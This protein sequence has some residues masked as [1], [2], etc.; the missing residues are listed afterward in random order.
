MDDYRA[1]GAPEWG[2]EIGRIPGP[3]RCW[4]GE[5]DAAVPVAVGRRVADAIPGAALELVP[6][7]GHFL[8]ADHGTEVFTGLLAD[9]G[10]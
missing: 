9:G 3:V 6:D 1:F 4:Q 10:V 8:V 7:A 5:E 2:F